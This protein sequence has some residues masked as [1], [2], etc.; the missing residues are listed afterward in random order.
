M[1]ETQPASSVVTAAANTVLEQRV[2]ELQQQLQGGPQ[3]VVAVESVVRRNPYC[4]L[5]AGALRVRFVK[6]PRRAAPQAPQAP[7][8]KR[9]DS[10]KGCTWIRVLYAQPSVSGHT[11]RRGLMP[12]V[13][14]RTMRSQAR[15]GTTSGTT[16]GVGS[17]VR[18]GVGTRRALQ[19]QLARQT[20]LLRE[21]QGLKVA[22]E[23]LRN[24]AGSAAKGPRAIEATPTP[25]HPRSQVRSPQTPPF[26]PVW[27]SKKAMVSNIDALESQIGIGCQAMGCGGKIARDGRLR[28]CSLLGGRVGRCAR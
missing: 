10:F 3:P 5:L 24:A 25:A 1:E 14:D 26:D 17:G 13:R 6:V 4:G 16:S 7:M 22:N 15:S 8:P 23:T 9:L 2:A 27:C 12:S 19:E 11:Q 20:A 21:Y 18:S 28:K